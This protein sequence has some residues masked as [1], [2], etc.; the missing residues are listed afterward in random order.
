VLDVTNP[1]NIEFIAC[2]V[3]LRDRDM[4]LYC[5]YMPPDSSIETYAAH[6]HAIETLFKLARF[7]DA[8]MIA[9]DFNLPN[10]NWVASDTMSNVFLPTN[11][12]SE[13]E[14]SVIDGLA[15]F[16]LNQLNDIVNTRNKLLDLIYC[17]CA[18]D[19]NICRSPYPLKHE[20]IHHN[21]VE[22]HIDCVED[23]SSVG[24]D[25][26]IYNFKMADLISLNT[27]LDTLD[28]EGMFRSCTDVDQ[29]VMRFYCALFTGF[30]LFI[31]KTVN[32]PR[33]DKHPPWYNPS[34][35]KLKNKKNNA[36][37]AYRKYGSVDEYNRYVDLR[38]QFVNLQNS[39]HE[40]YLDIIQ[41]N[42]KY[43][44]R[45][46]FSYVK[47]KRK[48]S[49]YPANMTYKDISSSDPFVICNLFADFFEEV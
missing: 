37:K 20:N 12:R 38:R 10:I 9:A 23:N 22:I 33:R 25:S 47:S 3:S 11:V 43:D 21:A 35:I 39:S 6:L 42:L 13:V 49:E 45:S 28:W 5:G 14:T 30:E 19:I 46:F 31:P 16:G 29:K 48:S 24:F 4:Y 17:S 32:R 7:N 40:R 18:D 8:V 27:F 2:R 26:L 1:S 41:T 36:Y 44:P 34:L 15:G